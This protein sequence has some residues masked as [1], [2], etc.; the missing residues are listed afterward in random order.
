VGV[1]PGRPLVPD[2]PDAYDLLFRS[3][4]EGFPDCDAIDLPCV[5][6]GGRLWGYLTGAPFIKENFLAHTPEGVREFHEIPLTGTF[7]GFMAQY[8]PKRRREFGRLHRAI[9]EW[10]GSEPVLRKVRH[11]G[12]IPD[13][14]RF[15]T[16]LGWPRPYVRTLHRRHEELASLARRGLLIGYTLSCGATPVGAIV[17]VKYQGRF[18][19]EVIARNRALDRFSPGTAVLHRAIEDLIHDEAVGHIDLG[20]G[21]PRYRHAATNVVEPR[22]RVY[23]LRK[24]VANRL[25]RLSHRGYQSLM[26]VLRRGLGKTH[27]PEER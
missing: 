23:L 20:M 12:E 26:R 4:A 21:L 15:V 10:A 17:G 22:A 8:R 19:M 11:V 14:V 25:R 3:L 13:L 9:V 1:A 2:E 6:T 16:D 24:T 27:A 18:S 5:P 7:E